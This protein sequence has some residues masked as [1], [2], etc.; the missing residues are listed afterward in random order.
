[1]APLP[2]LPPSLYSLSLP[3]FSPCPSFPY[4]TLPPPSCRQSLDAGMELRPFVEVAS[5]APEASTDCLVHVDFNQKAQPA[6]FE[7]WCRFHTA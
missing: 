6:K 4:P 3:P 2:P 7:I 5:L 1:M